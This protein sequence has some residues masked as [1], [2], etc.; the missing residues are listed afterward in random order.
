MFPRNSPEYA[1]IFLLNMS[2]LDNL[3]PNIFPSDNSPG[4]SLSQFAYLLAKHRRLEA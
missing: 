4:Q 1:Q 2:I 3:L